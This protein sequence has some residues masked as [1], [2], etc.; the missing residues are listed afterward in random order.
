MMTVAGTHSNGWRAEC[1]DQLVIAIVTPGMFDLVA[2]MLTQGQEQ[3]SSTP[4]G[5]KTSNV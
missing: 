1:G 2:V 5:M 4:A 3:V